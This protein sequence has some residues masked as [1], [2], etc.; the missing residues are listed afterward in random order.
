MTFVSLAFLAAL[1][2][3]FVIYY[4]VPQKIRYIILLVASC[5]FYMT[6]GWHYMIT[7]LGVICITCVAAR[8][9]CSARN[10]ALVGVA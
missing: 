1:A 2:V 8:I 9:A 7:L 5:L 3:L 10:I 4:A 6:W